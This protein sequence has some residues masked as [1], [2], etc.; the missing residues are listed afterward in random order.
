MMSNIM[1]MIPCMLSLIR[2]M[3]LDILLLISA[4]YAGKLFNTG[5]AELHHIGIARPANII[6]SD[7]KMIASSLILIFPPWYTVLTWVVLFFIMFTVSLN[8][9]MNIMTIIPCVNSSWKNK[10]ALPHN[11]RFF[12]QE[13][14]LNEIKCFRWSN[15]CNIKV[16]RNCQ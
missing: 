3:V 6:I 15:Q 8:M 10:N 1:L 14:K 9:A 5:N 12:M 11:W 16:N 13:K 2:S 7:R 4:I